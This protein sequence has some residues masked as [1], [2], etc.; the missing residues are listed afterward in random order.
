MSLHAF[1]R[2]LFV[3]T[4]A[5]IW[6]HWWRRKQVFTRSKGFSLP[7]GPPRKPVIGNVLDIP[8]QRAWNVFLN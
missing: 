5:V 1:G 7:P 6:G 4:G 3:I 8:R 2:F